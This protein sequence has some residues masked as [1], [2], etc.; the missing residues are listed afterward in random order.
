[1]DK[2]ENVIE[3]EGLWWKYKASEDWALR[4]INLKVKEGEFLAIMGP[5]G[6]GKSTLLCCLNG[7]IPQNYTGDIKGKAHIMGQDTRIARVSELSQT[8]G[9]VFQNPESQFIH[10]TVTDDI[11]FGPENMGLQMSEI[12]ERLSWALKTV[13]MEEFG[14]KAPRELSGGQKQR[15]AIAA[16]LVLKPEILVL[17]E[18]TSQLDPL[19]KSEVLTILED[20][21]KRLGLTII[22]AEHRSEDI[23]KFADRVI[24]LNN[25]NIELEG[26]P[27]EFFRN[28]EFLIERGVYPPQVSEL[29]D[30]LNRSQNFSSDSMNFPLTLDQMY[31]D[32]CHALNGRGCK[33]VK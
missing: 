33:R 11:V 6:A 7:L 12:D 32:L 31:V 27:K 2:E 8:V 3:L 20:L 29:A 1:V 24:L 22:I 10:L 16:A 13:R 18:P 28:V 17:D 23:V 5:N 26:T 19:G 25:G 14:E 30:L 15:I 4:N 21:R 9:M